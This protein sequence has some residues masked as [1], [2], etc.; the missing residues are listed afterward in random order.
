MKVAPLYVPM[1]SDDVLWVTEIERDLHAFPWTPGNFND[2]LSAGYGCWV[3]QRPSVEEGQDAEPF[4]YAVMLLVLD[5]A[6]LLNLTVSRAMQRQGW[7]SQLLGF[8][9]AQARGQGATQMFLEVRPS[10]LSA[11]ALYRRHK[12]QPIG[13]R[14]RYYPAA[15]GAREDA[16]VM[17]CRL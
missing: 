3:M 11:L 12:F 5:E 17:R 10:N 1:T 13:R 15:D 9:F 7:G 2:A 14:A 16:I 4:A 6:H 8:L